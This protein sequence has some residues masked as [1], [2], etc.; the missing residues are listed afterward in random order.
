MSNLTEGQIKTANWLLRYSRGQNEDHIRKRIGSLL[1][2]LQVDY[3]LSYRSPYASGPADI[4]LPRRRTIIETKALGLADDPNKRQARKNDETPKQQLDRYVYAEIAY[5]LNSLP[6]E[7]VSNRPWTG[8][9][10]DGQVWHVWT[11]PHEEK[12]RLHDS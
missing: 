11:Y 2:S 5:E 9:L 8:I 4:Y 6:L 1:E 3:E 7:D 12:L 10:T